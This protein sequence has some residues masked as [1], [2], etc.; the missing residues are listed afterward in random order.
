MEKGG[1]STLGN[2]Q[3]LERS[4]H[5]K[6]HAGKVV[7]DGSDVE[8]LTLPQTEVSAFCVRCKDWRPMLDP[9]QV[10]TANGHARLK[11][12]CLKCGTQMSKF[13]KEK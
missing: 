11:G 1:L 6:K 3:V 7:S 13:V 12:T 5:R 9:Q 4:A 10:V 2:L 8:S